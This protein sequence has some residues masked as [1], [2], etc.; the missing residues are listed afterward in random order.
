[1]CGDVDL[2]E[3]NTGTGAEVCECCLF[4][5]P[6]KEKY[7]KYLFEGM[8]NSQGEIQ[9]LWQTSKKSKFAKDDEYGWAMSIMGYPWRC[10]TF[11]TEKAIVTIHS[12][13]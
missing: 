2:S 3:V 8:V 4:L 6:H 12:P 13:Y 7:P 11:H 5:Y 9:S 10:K 1:M